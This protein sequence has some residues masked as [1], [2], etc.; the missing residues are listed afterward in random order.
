MRKILQFSFI[1]LSVIV[2]FL[3]YQKDKKNIQNNSLIKVKSHPSQTA[4]IP[5]L[6][7]YID[8]SIASVPHQKINQFKS[9]KKKTY[10]HL[11]NAIPNLSGL[12]HG[13]QM[14]QN[15]RAI[16]MSEYRSEMGEQIFKDNNYA[17]F[18]YE[19]TPDDA[20]EYVAYDSK[21]QKFYPIST[22]LKIE[23]I[24]L[25]Q[26]E[27]LVSQGYNEFYYRSDLKLLY[28]QTERKNL[29]AT[30]AELEKQ[31]LKPSFEIL[32][33]TDRPH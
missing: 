3:I 27:S 20:W 8:R 28:L 16:K 26:R 4:I 6:P 19:S 15:L 33:L 5:A 21:N 32:T 2:C 13:Y 29:M 9:Y 23:K 14:A 30:Y 22:V 24:D 12:P 18:K 31:S 17:Y 11:V 1:P 25:K 10:T 7:R